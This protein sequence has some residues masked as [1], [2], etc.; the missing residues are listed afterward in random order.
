MWVGGPAENGGSA[1]ALDALAIRGPNGLSAEGY[2]LGIGRGSDARLRV[3]LAGADPTGTFYAAQTLRQ[4]VVS[5]GGRDLLPGIWIRDWP[6]TRLRGVVEGFYGPPWSTAD[7]L[8][9]LDFLGATKQ[10]VYVYSPKND[11]YLRAQWRDP[12]PGDQLLVTRQLVARAAADH[13]QFT[14]ALSPGLSVCYSSESDEQALVAKF[15]SMWNI[16]VRSFAIPFDDISYTKWNC[17]QDATRFGTGGGA[18]GAAQAFLLDHIQHDFIDTHPSAKRL[19]MVPTEFF[20]VSDSPYT[21]ALR[22][23]LD[24]RIIV[25]WTGDGVTPA[26]ITAGQAAQAQQVFGHDVL[27]WDNYPVNDSMPTRLLLGPYIGRE[28]GVTD[29]VVGVTANPMIE[30]APSE[31]AEFTSGDYLWN[32]TSYDPSTAWLA[33]LHD[34]GESAWQALRVFAENNYSSILN[35]TESPA[36]A[37]LIGTFWKV[38]DS[39]QS[40]RSAGTALLDYFGQMAAAPGALTTVMHDSAFP[41]EARPWIDKLGIYGKAGEAAVSMLLA[42]QAGD[43]STA[44]TDRLALVSLLQ[45]AAAIPQVVAPGVMDP[46]LTQAVGLVPPPGIEPGHKV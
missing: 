31:I 1:A 39:G 43:T 19:E 3:V 23:Q 22:N 44:S 27:V 34:V 42:Q 15:D 6:A 20:T 36:L 12:Y 35:A 8:S 37:P 4:L 33:A 25:E 21:M 2:V 30:S 45:Q 7:R 26:T 16:G 32:A 17:A 11:P 41:T 10:D 38:H 24:P 13:V 28:P 46:F 14:Y 29:H 5:Q 9:Q 18:A 40:L